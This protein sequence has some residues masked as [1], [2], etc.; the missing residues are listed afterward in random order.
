[1]PIPPKD[2]PNHAQS[3][4]EMTHEERPLT[5]QE[6]RGIV[7]ALARDRQKKRPLYEKLRM[8]TLFQR[9]E[10]DLT[11]V[12]IYPDQIP[13]LK[14]KI[15]EEFQTTQIQSGEMVGIT[16][17]QS[18]GERQTQMSV[19]GGHGVWIRRI[20]RSSG[21]LL[22]H[23]VG[24]IGSFIDAYLRDHPHA[25]H[26][27]DRDS[28]VLPTETLPT[29]DEILAIDPQGRVRWSPI[30]E[31][32]RHPPNGDLQ[33]T[34]TR[35]GRCLTTTRSHSLLVSVD[36]P[37]MTTE[38]SRICPARSSDV[39]PGIHLMPRSSGR[40]WGCILDTRGVES[41]PDLQTVDDLWSVLNTMGVL[42]TA[43]R[44]SSEAIEGAT[45]AL[46]RL[47]ESALHTPVGDCRHLV[48][49]LVEYIRQD[50]AGLGGVVGTWT[51]FFA[52]PEERLCL[53]MLAL[54]LDLHEIAVDSVW[55]T[56]SR[57]GCVQIRWPDAPE[58]PG[59]DRVVDA[60]VIPEEV[61]T[62]DSDH[63][64]HVYDL[65]VASETFLLLDGIFVHNTLNT[66]HSAGLAVQ[67]VLS[68]VP[69][70][71][72]LLNATKEARFSS[73]RFRLHP[74]I[75]G[76]LESSH[77]VAPDASDK[78]IPTAGT[79]APPSLS[80]QDIRNVIRHRIVRLTMKH[81]IRSWDVFL[82]PCDEIWYDPFEMLYSD[83]FR[84]LD[85]GVRIHLDQDLLY[86][87]RIRIDE[88][89]RYLESQFDDIACV[90][91]PQHLGQLDVFIDTSLIRC[92]ID[93]ET[94]PAP[95]PNQPSP[96]LNPFLSPQWEGENP[97]MFFIE[98][99]FVPRLEEVS[100]CG[101]PGIRDYVVQKEED[102]HLW[103][104]TQGNNFSMLMGLDWI[105]QTTASSNNM[106]DIYNLAGIEATRQFLIDEFRRVISSDG[107]FIH[108]SHV[109]LL[110]DIMTHQG[111]ILSVSRYGMKKEQTSPLA[112]AS[113]EE[114]L[115][116]FLTAGFIGEEETIEGVSASIICGKRSKI[117]T[118]LCRLVFDPP[119]PIVK[120]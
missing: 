52:G 92:G 113:F 76:A 100:V 11:R 93:M 88:L 73:T 5:R 24:T 80:I 49:R 70:F 64:Y 68:G 63:V 43:P 33:K 42:S 102:G 26:D 120:E 96:S 25:V 55:N 46:C 78:R 9:L 116:H 117:G 47:S 13:R 61:F 14:E 54:C 69:R 99:V 83:R 72:E 110:V 41:P 85:K 95:L 44:P 8:R 10:Q 20:D 111:I 30:T 106:W 17:A 58:H 48:H 18:I 7:S 3:S 71:L 109:S 89:A 28:R 81:L 75:L 90:F 56:D 12:C 62:A 32:S 91:S 19:A 65:S 29:V 82:A 53:Q 118:G 119:D 115:D 35:S 77:V 38:R 103:V 4:P 37:E 107:T 23:H 15:M 67:T 101:I 50:L 36:R 104:V 31:Y 112:K 114:C 97:E 21:R 108:P 105:D 84:D 1:M 51:A 94:R 59:W 22:G 6:I 86:Q 74:S 98:Q 27:L 66:F 45:T 2:I 39:R 79:L 34:R 87:H 40:S 57:G 16:C 60:Q